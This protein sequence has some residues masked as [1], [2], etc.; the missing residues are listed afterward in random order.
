[1]GNLFGL[2]GEDVIHPS[3]MILTVNEINRSPF[4]SG[5]GNQVKQDEIRVNLTL[6]N[7]GM[8]TIRVD[9]AADFSI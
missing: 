7:T 1:M 5:L 4:Q 9:P 2:M 6:V 3:G 8:N